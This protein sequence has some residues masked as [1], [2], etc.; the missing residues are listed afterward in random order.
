MATGE[1][2]AQRGVIRTHTAEVDDATYAGSFR[3]APKVFGVA[4]FFGHP[5]FA[6]ANAVHQIDCCIN[7]VHGPSGNV[8]DLTLNYFN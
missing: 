7:I 8:P 2:F 5:V 1:V 4:Y 6:V 3:G